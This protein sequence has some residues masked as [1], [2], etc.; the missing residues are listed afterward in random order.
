MN[1]EKENALRALIKPLPHSNWEADYS[2]GDIDRALE[3]F[4]EGY[5]LNLE[6][7]FQRGHVWTMKQRSAYI[8]AMLRRA[9]P[10]S[11][12]LIQWN[13]PSWMGDKPK[14]SDLVDEIVIVDGLQR[15][16]TV[17]MFMRGELTAFGLKFDDFDDTEFM[18]RRMTYNI[19]FA[20]FT[21]QTRAELLAFYLAINSGG[22]PHTP[23]ELARVRALLEKK[24]RA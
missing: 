5:G 21:I 17:R 11:A 1:K 14:N 3:R 18:L 4:H 23:E 8:E 22:T 20:M 9:L 10:S 6:P 24:E 7:D 2:L 13:C 16:T 19:R 15:L 12:L